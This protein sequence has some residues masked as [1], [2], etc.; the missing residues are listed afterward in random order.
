MIRTVALILYLCALFALGL[1]RLC[2]YLVDLDTRRRVHAAVKRMT[3]VDQLRRYGR[4]DDYD[5]RSADYLKSRS[6]RR[7]GD[8]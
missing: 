3:A 8:S 1:R 6:K 7:D 5:R 2:R 4:E